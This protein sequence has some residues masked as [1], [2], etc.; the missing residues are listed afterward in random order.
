ME[1]I[2]ELQH[3]G[4]WKEVKEVEMSVNNSFKKTVWEKREWVVVKEG[5]G[6]KG[7]YC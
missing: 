2:N 3:S 4:E 6:E 7:D 1:R 5:H